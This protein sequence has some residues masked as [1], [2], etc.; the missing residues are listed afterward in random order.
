M[1]HLGISVFY[2]NQRRPIPP[3]TKEN[4][5]EINNHA[6]NGT[7]GQNAESLTPPKK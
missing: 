7:N 4:I 3:L 1:H 5:P 6:A 2:V